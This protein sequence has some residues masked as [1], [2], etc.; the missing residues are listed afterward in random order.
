MTKKKF[1]L[2]NIK[3]KIIS[4]L[5]AVAIPVPVATFS[6]FAAEKYDVD[7]SGTVSIT[8]ATLI[9]KYLIEKATLNS[10]QLKTADCNGDGKV[11]V[12]DA[13]FIQKYLIGISDTPDETDTYILSS[14]AE[15]TDK[16]YSGQKYKLT[17]TEKAFIEKIVTGEFGTSYEG[18][19]CIAQCI[20]DALVYGFC[21]DPMNLRKSSSQGGM[22]YV[23]YNEN[24]TNN[25]KNAVEF[26]FDD[27]GSAVQHRMLVMCTKSYSDANPGNWHSTQNFILQY[28]NVLFYDYWI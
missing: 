21:D 13:T 8:D 6:T 12:Q 18:S 11:N 19:V 1:K 5:M 16:S 17:S 14:Q 24:V 2:S 28:S 27:G 20:R 3:L 15:K 23:G 25:A 22:G 4:A 10:Q 9:Q 7:G 26:V